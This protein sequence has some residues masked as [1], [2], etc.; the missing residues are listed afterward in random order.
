MNSLPSYLYLRASLRPAR[1]F[2]WPPIATSRFSATL[3][4]INPAHI[5]N[6]PFQPSLSC[7]TFGASMSF[8]FKQRVKLE[9]RVAACCPENLH[10]FANQSRQE[11]TLP[12]FTEAVFAFDNAPIE[13]SAPLCRRGIFATP[14]FLRLAV[15]FFLSSFEILFVSSIPRRNR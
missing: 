3:R 11:F 13:A 9:G 12:R 1:S 14:S 7:S 4:S 6:R 2:F 5:R 8:C 15:A 10:P